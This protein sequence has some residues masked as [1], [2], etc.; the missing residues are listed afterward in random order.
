MLTV[1]EI[2]KNQR[3]KKDLSLKEISKQIK[4][5]E[6]Y[7]RALESNQW[8]IFPSKVYI[9]GVIKSYSSFLGLNYKKVLPFFYRDYDDKESITFKKRVADE[10]FTP[11]IKNTFR[12]L[13]FVL[14]FIFFGYF[15]YQIKLFFTPPKLIL[16]SPKGDTFYN[17][18]IIKIVGKTE[19]ETEI[20][21]FGE[22]I[23]PTRDGLFEYD[24]PLKKG[25]NELVIELIG[26]N[27]RKTVFKK[28]FYKKSSS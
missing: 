13:T 23:Y 5:K 28:I 27:G 12:A 24:F 15:L 2:L 9:E 11:Q 22:R 3:L 14:I 19:K 16:L 8:S 6:D 25:K 7:L 10:Y 21:I 4:V 17:E 18:K 26:A 1:G 20:T